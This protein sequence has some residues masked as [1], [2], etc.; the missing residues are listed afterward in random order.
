MSALKVN[1]DWSNIYA[2]QRASGLTI[3]KFCKQKRITPY[4]YY[5]H[6]EEDNSQSNFIKAELVSEVV[7]S[8]PTVLRDPLTLITIAGEI[9]LPANDAVNI[10]VK[11]IKGLS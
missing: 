2:E 5:L 1:Q 10:L 4:A 3:G 11:L 9:S 7:Q 8:K 6:K